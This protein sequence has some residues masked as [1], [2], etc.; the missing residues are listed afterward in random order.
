MLEEVRDRVAAQAAREAAA[1]GREA[2][3]MERA[4]RGER[5]RQEEL[6]LANR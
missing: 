4:T 6:L 1:V 2:P 5:A 3:L